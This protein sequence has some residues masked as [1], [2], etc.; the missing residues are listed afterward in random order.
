MTDYYEYSIPELVQLLGTRFKD[1]R[2]RSRMTQRDVA[3]LS[4]L[5]V[6]TIHKFENGRVPNLSLSTFLLL[7]KAIGCI[8]GIDGLMP[9][10]PESPY[11]IK[12]SGKKAQRIRH[13]STKS[14]T[15]E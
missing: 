9:E 6:N 14:N 13:V 4:G 5:T 3:E 7:M 15:L 11:L 12:E 10:L 2:M 1:Y 8:N